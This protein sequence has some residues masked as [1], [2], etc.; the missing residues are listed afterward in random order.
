MPSMFE[1]LYVWIN[2]FLKSCVLFL[3]GTHERPSIL[4]GYADE[5][6]LKTP[7]LEAGEPLASEWQPAASTDELSHL[8]Y[9][10]WQVMLLCWDL[11]HWDWCQP[12]L[13]LG[14]QTPYLSPM[15]MVSVT[16]ACRISTAI[17]YQNASGYSSPGH[18]QSWRLCAI[19][20]NYQNSPDTFN[21]LQSAMDSER[22]GDGRSRMLRWMLTKRT[23]SDRQICLKPT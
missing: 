1:C 5:K 7:A 13:H 14:G 16:T 8:D 2:I 11:S 19:K 18:L 17:L 20:K 3:G 9:C 10:Q 22:T 12:Q 4:K 21:L 6:R 23:L 15:H